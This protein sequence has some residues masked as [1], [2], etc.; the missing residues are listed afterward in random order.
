MLNLVITGGTKGIGRAVVEL[1][2]K[3]GWNVCTCGRTEEGLKRLKEE[4]KERKNLYVKV[5]DVGDRNS[6]KAFVEFCRE[7]LGDF[8]LLIN[9]AS[10]LG[11][12]LPIEKY[13]EEVWEE[14]I[15]GQSKRRLLHHQ[16]CPALYEEW[17]S[18]NK[19]ILWGRQKTRTLLGCLCGFKVRSGRF[20]SAF[21]RGAKA[22]RN[23][24]VCL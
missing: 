24:G 9:N 1:F 12:R 20:F 10:I 15:K 21:G 8:D 19:P 23:K 4:L 7:K 13:P 17:R 18:D 3:E 5:C 6:A 2:L 22:K 16:V 11:E 14:V